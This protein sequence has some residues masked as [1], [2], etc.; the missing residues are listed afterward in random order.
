MSHN[1]TTPPTY[2]VE[3]IEAE[4]IILETPHI[5]RARG[6]FQQFIDNIALAIV[7]GSIREETVFDRTTPAVFEAVQVALARF[8]E[9]NELYSTR[10]TLEGVNE[11]LDSE[12]FHFRKNPN[13]FTN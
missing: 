9:L 8:D 7:S 3:H 6:R 11:Y 2:P 5:Q 1:N 4:V 10:S 13:G 12:K